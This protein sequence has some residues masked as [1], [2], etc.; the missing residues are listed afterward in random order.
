MEKLKRDN[1]L[2]ILDHLNDCHAIIITLVV[3][4]SSRLRSFVILFIFRGSGGLYLQWRE[5]DWGRRAS[6]GHGSGVKPAT[7]AGGLD[8]LNHLLK[9]PSY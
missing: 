3:Q 4:V 2:L 8:P 1:L 7:A 5:T 6:R 9:P